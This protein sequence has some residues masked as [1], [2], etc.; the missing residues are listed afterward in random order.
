MSVEQLRKEYSRLVGEA[1]SKM[2]PWKGKE[3][4]MPLEVSDNIS[5]L[6]GE[7]DAYKAR[8]DTIDRLAGAQESGEEGGGT[9]AAHHGWRPATQYEG[10]F[11]VDQKAWREV[12]IDS[13]E[14]NP[15]WGIVTQVKKT[16]RY[17]VPVATQQKG[18]SGAFEG[19]CRKGFNGL[20]PNDRKTLTEGVDTAGGFL[21]DD[22]YHTEMIKKIATNATVRPNARVVQ[23]SREMAQWPK[24]VY[25]TDDE[26]TS[27]VRLTWTGETPASATTHRVTEPTFGL[28][29]IPVHTAMASMPVSNNLL[30]DAAFDVRGLSVELF[31][32]AF[33]LGENNTFINGDGV[34]QPMGILTQVD[35]TGKGPSSVVSGN[36]STLTADGL[37]DLAYAL[38]AQYETNAK[39]M[40]TKATEKVIRKLKDSQN[41]YLW[42][43]W[44]QQGNFAP[45]P[46]DLL[47]Y[48]TMRDEFVP[49]IAADAYPIIFGDLRAYLIL[50]RIGFSV[51]W[52]SE[53]YAETNITLLLARK[54]VGGSIV[55]P[56]R[57]KAQKVS[58]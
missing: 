49:E 12:E 11:E 35:V 36:A 4:E 41:N 47:G 19:Y 42:P 45:A 3:A 55:E 44:P 8:I 6:L 37:V 1:N 58:T 13:L 24:L 48:P 18:Y 29:N 17:H 54:R 25:N 9:T 39:W 7:A 14:V 32:E 38:P 15:I 56:W 23:T 53:L 5:S 51:Q 43:I 28:I 31:S 33:R 40:F 30:E 34:N 16:I 10:T 26:W 52:L 2:A 46:R 22:D 57:V 50:D 21:A 20:G 27:A